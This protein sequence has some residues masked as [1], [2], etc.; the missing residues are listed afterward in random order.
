VTLEG[1]G[2]FSLIDPEHSCWQTVVAAVSA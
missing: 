2:H 1:V